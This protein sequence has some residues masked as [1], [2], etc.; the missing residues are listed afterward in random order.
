VEPLRQSLAETNELLRG[1]IL[2]WEGLRE[3][4]SQALT[5]AAA[6]ARALA[7]EAASQAASQTATQTASHIVE[8]LRED[9]A[10]AL[11]E[12]ADAPAPDEAPPVATSAEPA[13]EHQPAAPAFDVSNWHGVLQVRLARLGP[14]TLA[15]PAE[16]VLGQVAETPRRLQLPRG[17]TLVLTEQ[18]A[19]PD[20]GLEQCWGLQDQEVAAQYLL[21]RDA[22]VCYAL[23]V[24]RVLE[25]QALHFWG[26]PAPLGA[27]VGVAA[28]AVLAESAQVPGLQPGACELA[29]LVDPGFVAWVHA[30][31]QLDRELAARAASERGES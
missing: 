23:R 25:Q 18:G 2:G 13:G 31:S 24:H 27:P 19:L 11:A 20:V 8:A 17:D 4:L 29:L 21:L 16:S 22:E 9:R 7:S 12:R 15:L 30:Q 6:Q 26:L 28:A 14:W 10:Q 3:T 1:Q 5:A